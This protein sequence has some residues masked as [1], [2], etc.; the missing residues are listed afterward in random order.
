MNAPLGNGTHCIYV[1][2]KYVTAESGENVADWHFRLN[3]RLQWT[4]ETFQIYTGTLEEF[5][6]L[7]CFGATVSQRA[8]LSACLKAWREMFTWL[9]WFA[10]WSAGRVCSTF[11]H[12]R[13]KN[14]WCSSQACPAVFNMGV[15]IALGV[16]SDGWFIMENPI[17]MKNFVV[18]LFQETSMW[19]LLSYPGVDQRRVASGGFWAAALGFR[20]LR[21]SCAKTAG[22]DWSVETT[23]PVL[24]GLLLRPYSASCLCHFESSNAAR[25]KIYQRY[26]YWKFWSLGNALSVHDAK[27][28]WSSYSIW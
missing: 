4:S 6:L 22:L 14:C 9:K 12:I 20:A 21:I 10:A 2:K 17:E 15:S 1:P 19:L 13:S 26:V 18:P 16:S 28:R 11:H 7:W 25:L 8:F 23:R 3:V 24:R 5:L 27:E